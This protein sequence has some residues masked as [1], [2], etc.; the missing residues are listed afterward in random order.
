MATRES[1]IL[2][3]DIFTVQDVDLEGKKFERGNKGR[4]GFSIDLV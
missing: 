4:S 3:D 1:N 2:F